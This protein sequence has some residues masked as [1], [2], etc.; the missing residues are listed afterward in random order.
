M[1]LK[2][3]GGWT[4]SEPTCA[5][6]SRSAGGRGSFV[7]CICS[8]KIFFKQNQN[9]HLATAA[10]DFYS[11][12]LQNIKVFAA[13]SHPWQLITFC[14]FYIFLVEHRKPVSHIAQPAARG[15]E[16]PYKEPRRVG[17]AL[18]HSP[19]PFCRVMQAVQKA[20]RSSCPKPPSW[21][22]SWE[23]CWSTLRPTASLHWSVYCSYLGAL[24][25]AA[26]GCGGVLSDQS[27]TRLVTNGLPPL[28][29]LS[30]WWKIS[31]CR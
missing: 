4:A 27:Q 26:R 1:S 28:A 22:A 23:R 25:A 17:S 30:R 7:W 18:P 5:P 14:W 29:D 6:Q 2:T 24:V 10:A 16:E 21:P 9:I 31:P 3:Y 19:L 13:Y 12:L 11:E 20:Q 15:C 8:W